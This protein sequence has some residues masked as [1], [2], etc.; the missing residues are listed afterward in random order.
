M[1]QQS[2]KKYLYPAILIFVIIASLPQP[3]ILY[4][5]PLYYKD[6]SLGNNKKNILSILSRQKYTQQEIYYDSNDRYIGGVKVKSENSIKIIIKQY[7]EKEEI[8]LV[9]DNNDILFDIYTKKSPIDLRDYID[10]KINMTEIYGKP[11]EE[12]AYGKYIVAWSLDKKCHAVYLIYDQEKEYMIIN[13]RDNNLDKN[14]MPRQGLN[15][16]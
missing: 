2:M 8:L 1:G 6:F 10:H 16:H 15:D 12:L 13:M 7:M 9:F 3:G 11:A 14:Y 4:S 5:K